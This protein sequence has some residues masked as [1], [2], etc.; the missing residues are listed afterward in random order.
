VLGRHFTNY[1]PQLEAKR[2]N[3]V[4]NLVISE[5]QQISNE[6]MKTVDNKGKTAYFLINFTPI[7][8]E[9]GD[10][11]G[12]FGIMRNITEMHLMEKKLRENTRRLEEKIKEQLSQAEELRHIQ[13]INDDIINNVPIG[14]FSMDPTGIML[15]KTRAE[16]FMGHLP[17]NR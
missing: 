10:I 3:T 15:T 17:R 16:A 13:T 9:S 12:V 5:G 2:A 8:S 11:K 4:F 14:I 7:R 1:I 6:I